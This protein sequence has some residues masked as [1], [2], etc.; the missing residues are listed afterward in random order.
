MR[1]PSEGA[2][3]TLLA[4]PV[5]VHFVVRL[6]AEMPELDSEEHQELGEE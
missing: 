3:A 1:V 2:V 4:V 5:M 6:D